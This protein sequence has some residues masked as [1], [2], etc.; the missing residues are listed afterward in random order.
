MPRLFGVALPGAVADVTEAFGGGVEDDGVTVA[1]LGELRA[2]NRI[3]MTVAMPDE[4]AIRIEDR[5]AE[6]ALQLAKRSEH[7]VDGAAGRL[8]IF[9]YG[10]DQ[11]RALP[12]F[13]RGA[14]CLAVRVP[15]GEKAIDLLQKPRRSC[16][17]Q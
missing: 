8:R 15:I 2:R 10:H 13:A 4:D 11:E 3:D 14:D 16:I 6:I 5:H 17:V 9:V 1:P 7:A 12:K